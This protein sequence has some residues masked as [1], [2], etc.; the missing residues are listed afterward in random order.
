MQG[1]L[2]ST[3]YGH[4]VHPAS[5]GRNEGEGDQGAAVLHYTFAALSGQTEAEL[6]MGFRHWVGVGVKQNCQDALPWYKSAADK[7]M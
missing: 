6:T 4:S 1:F 2:H 7:G 5:S 3:N